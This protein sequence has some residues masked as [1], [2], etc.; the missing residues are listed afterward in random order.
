M[1][2]LAVN[3]NLEDRACLVVGAGKVGRRKISRL[4][5]AGAR[6]KIVARRLEPEVAA[7][8]AQGRAQ[9]LGPKFSPRMLEGVFLVVAATDDPRLNERISREAQARGV[10]VN[11]VDQPALCSFILPAVV[12]RGRLSLAVGTGGA[13]PACARRIRED[14]AARYG[15]EWDQ[16]LELMALVRARLMA[17]EPDESRRREIF[18]ALA[19]AG[20]ARLLA[21]GDHAG[22]ETLVTSLLGPNFNFKALGFHPEGKDEP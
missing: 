14:L 11:I 8:V 9:H 21:A 2:F 19:G 15:A 17:V 5:E 18:E 22:L 4:A 7:L 1:G 20:P 6:L 13:S 3:L 16:A 10:L 12:N